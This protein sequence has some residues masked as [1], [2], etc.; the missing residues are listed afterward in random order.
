MRSV[1][2]SFVRVLFFLQSVGK[3][4]GKA[5]GEPPLEL[6]D[7]LRH[8]VPHVLHHRRHLVAVAREDLREG[9]ALALARCDEFIER[10]VDD[11][12]HFPEELVAV[13][14]FGCGDPGEFEDF[15]DGKLL[16]LRVELENGFLK[17]EDAPQRL[18]VHGS[19]KRGC[20][21]REVEPQLHLPAREAL[22]ETLADGGFGKAQRIVKAQRQI[23]K[24]GIDRTAFRSDGA[25][26]GLAVKGGVTRHACD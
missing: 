9:R 8:G 19:R 25:R 17:R 18:L 23:E 21:R 2:S 16:R 5:F 13:G 15:S 20:V 22:L 6:R 26:E 11:R 1:T 14:G 7:D 10:A 4:I 24:A 12:E 3:R